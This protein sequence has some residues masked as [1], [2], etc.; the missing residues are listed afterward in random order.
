MTN[1]AT[2]ADGAIDIGRLIDE[3]PWGGYQKWVVFLTALAVVM[4]GFDNHLLALAIPA[5]LKEWGIARNA[6]ALATSV[7]L[8]GMALGTTAG[9][10][11]ADRFGR[12]PTVI[13]S[14]M[15]FGVVTVAN[16][17]V[18]DIG[19]MTAMR[20][21]AGIG[22]GSLMP[23]AASTFAEFTPARRRTLAIT[24]GLVCVPLGGILSGLLAA[25]I[26]PTLGW[27]VFFMVGGG[28]AIAIGLVQLAALPESPRYLVRAGRADANLARVLGRMGHAGIDVA[29]VVD[30][31]AGAVA[32]GSVARLF[33]RDL[34]R[35]TIGLWVA[36]FAALMCV[37]METQWMPT[38]LSENGY[39]LRTASLA[40]SYL[41][42][43]GTLACFFGVVALGRFGSRV[44]LMAMATA[45]I[46]LT[47][48]LTRY[49]MDPSQSAMP[50]LGL[51][52]MVGFLIGGL[53]IMIYPVAANIYPTSLRATGIG[54]AVGIGRLG[55]VIS[56][57]VATGSMSVGGWRGFFVL[58]AV[59]MAVTLAGLAVIRR[60]I[61]RTSAR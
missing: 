36:F 48:G 30:P 44:A 21:F 57:F 46:V 54:W 5:L 59:G 2:A 26:L 52:A 14:V 13:G 23:A 31:S 6:F 12:R 53:Q 41:S 17:F 33:A 10:M 45:A 38:V 22:L 24:L 47:L 8:L 50:L 25:E 55:S 58:L 37:Y 16:A 35:D 18:H 20:F 9:G 60:H 34:V 51:L 49:P 28:L 3:R 40:S 32:K 7:G 61:A 15:A 39:S 42:F 43:G 29:A 19:S 27:R 4:D 1:Q 56:P 11:I